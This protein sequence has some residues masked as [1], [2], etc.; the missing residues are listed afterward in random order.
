MITLRKKRE[1]VKSND[2]NSNVIKEYERSNERNCYNISENESKVRL[3]K[4][5]VK[6]KSY[7]LAKEPSAKSEFTASLFYS[8]YKRSVSSQFSLLCPFNRNFSRRY[9]FVSLGY[10]AG[11]G[12]RE[13]E[14]LQA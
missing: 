14:R 13:R 11:K 1:D 5:A 9:N 4:F 8:L 12:E 7:L 2:Y 3:K 10:G 6:K